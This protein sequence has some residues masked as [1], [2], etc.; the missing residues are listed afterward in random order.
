M[1]LMFVV[2]VLQILKGN[3][4]TYIAEVRELRPP[5]IA[6]RIRFIPYSA[7]QRTVCMRVELYGCP[8]KGESLE[9]LAPPTPRLLVHSLWFFSES[10][11]CRYSLSL[12]L[13]VCHFSWFAFCQY[14]SIYAQIPGTCSQ[15]IAAFSV[16]NWVTK[17]RSIPSFPLPFL[18]TRNHLFQGQLPTWSEFVY[19]QKTWLGFVQNACLTSHFAPESKEISL[20]PA[21]LMLS[22]HMINFS[23]LDQMPW[24]LNH[25]SSIRVMQSKC[26]AS[27]LEAVPLLIIVRYSM[28]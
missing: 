19:L 5:I 16:W 26:H 17:T 24:A 18:L 6:K 10:G 21:S 2:V 22:S 11:H 8:W 1:K 13:A 20:N 25:L 3:S 7:H 12:F 28:R 15:W 9:G 4:N 23:C 27:S 14:C